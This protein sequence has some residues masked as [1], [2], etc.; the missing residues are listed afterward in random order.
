MKSIKNIENY[1]IKVN[2]TILL[3]KYHMKKISLTNIRGSKI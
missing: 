1:K 3:T 2:E